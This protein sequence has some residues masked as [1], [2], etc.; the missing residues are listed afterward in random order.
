[1]S[2]VEVVDFNFFIA[3]ETYKNVFLAFSLLLQ[4]ALIYQNPIS[5]HFFHSLLRM[6]SFTNAKAK[7]IAR[8]IAISR[9]RPVKFWYCDKM[10]EGMYPCL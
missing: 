10:R 9:N 5:L 8:I 7:R 3:D 1:M 4:I 2:A 6:I